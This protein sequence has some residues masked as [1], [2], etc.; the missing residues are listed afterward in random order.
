MTRTV[1]RLERENELLRAA[2]AEGDR[3]IETLRELIHPTMDGYCPECGGGCLIGFGATP[4]R[5]ALD[6][7]SRPRE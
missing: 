4:A 3:R 2:V 7:L 6:D 1:T 5:D